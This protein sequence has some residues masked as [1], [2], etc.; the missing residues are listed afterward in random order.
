MNA[1]WFIRALEFTRQ[2]L[3]LNRYRPDGKLFIAK[4]GKKRDHFRET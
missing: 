2:I 1:N 4:K 3:L